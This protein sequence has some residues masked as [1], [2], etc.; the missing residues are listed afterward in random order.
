MPIYGS[1]IPGYV[2]DPK[3]RE[4]LEAIEWFVMGR[5]NARRS[6]VFH[7]KKMKR[8]TCLKISAPV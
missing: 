6:G 2:K 8:L 4:A 3:H 1:D 5:K 7:R